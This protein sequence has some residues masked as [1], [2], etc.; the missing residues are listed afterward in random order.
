MKQS[1]KAEDPQQHSPEVE[2]ETPLPSYM[3]GPYAPVDGEIDAIELDVA[4]ALPAELDGRYFRN[5]PNPLPGVI[6]PH[7][8]VGDGMLHGVRLRN[9]RAH[10]YRNRW[11][12]TLKFD[13]GS[14]LCEDGGVNRAYSTAN[15]SIIRHGGRLFALVE[16][17]FPI[18]V[19]PDLDTVGAFDFA[20]ELTTT[21][22]A[23]PKQDPITGELHF[24]GCD[25]RAPFVTYHR[26][27]A[28]GELVFS[29]PVDV[30]G[31]TMMHDFAIT[32]NHIIW[33]DLPVTLQFSGKGLPF[34]W[35]DDYGARLGVMS[36]N[37]GPVRWFEVEPCYVF[38]VGNACE[39]GSGRII[40][41]AIRYDARAWNSTWPAL[42][43]ETPSPGTGRGQQLYRWALDPATGRV[44][45]QPLDDRSV[46]FPT[47]HARHVG[48]PNRHLYAV[49]RETI[50]K[51]DVDTGKSTVHQL[52]SGWN[53]GEA[54]FIPAAD[55]RSE[56]EGWL[57]SLVI[58]DDTNVPSQLQILDATAVEAG[59][60]AAV[61]LPRR[62]PIGFHGNWITEE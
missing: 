18:E 47:V 31:P 28:A 19:T 2:S 42:A 15:T 53:A 3:T 4:G 9:G 27:S 13:G 58:H 46:E 23:H 32:E 1:G 35:S 14:P 30:P 5:G 56:D 52:G 60:V 16:G 40:L 38:H 25:A 61:C 39:D 57:M 59:P 45:E 54:V 48:R 10:W 51:Y 62:V 20:G 34:Q 22:T 29:T 8:F 11:V 6:S 50:V 26:L 33:L 17:S 7:W 41:D 12:R 37:G 36:K 43:G 49:D 24:F 55:A 44:A 21:M